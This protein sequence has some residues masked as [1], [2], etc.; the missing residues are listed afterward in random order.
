[1]SDSGGITHRLS[2]LGWEAYGLFIFL[3]KSNPHFT[4]V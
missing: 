2:D 3:N 4:I 1:M